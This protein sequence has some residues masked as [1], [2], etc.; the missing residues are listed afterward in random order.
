MPRMPSQSSFEAL[1][2][3]REVYGTRGPYSA[4]T[5]TAGNRD[6]VRKW[7]VAEGVPSIIA[8]SASLIQLRAA[9]ADTS[10][11]EIDNLACRD[12]RDVPQDDDSPFTPAETREIEIER[13]ADN[14]DTLDL[15]RQTKVNG[16]QRITLEQPMQPAPMTPKATDAAG[17]LAA[18]LALATQQQPIDES[19]V[20]EIITQELADNLGALN[21][22][23]NA[24]AKSIADMMAA[25]PRSLNLTINNKPIG[26]LDA[27]RHPRTELLLKVVATGTPAYIV[28]PAGSGKT[29][30]AKQVAAA[31][32]LPFYLQG[33]ASGSHEFLGFLDAHGNYQ[34]TPFRQA[35]EFGGVFLADEI[36]GGD[37]AAPLVINSAISNGIMAFPDSK[38]P[39]AVHPDFRMIAAANTY[40]N[41]AD[42]QYV[43]RTQL[44]AAT[45]D[46]FAMINWQYD[47]VLEM[48]LAGNDDWCRFVQKV[49]R[50][51]A[52]LS[53]RHIVSPRASIMGA[54][55]LA[56]GID[57]ETVAEMF[58]W[59]GLTAADIAR[60]KAGM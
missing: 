54:R 39:I 43:G 27:Q 20:R 3:C 7:L 55:N 37:A 51:I 10:D 23:Q 53:L 16:P 38:T 24:V 33:A 41:G 14:M 2:A 44:D 45:L 22:L 13:I 46:R 18:F 52:K 15:T 35:V 1:S 4:A 19:K 50:A 49:R 29:T 6:A 32:N 31:L 11:K 47:E 34:G 17:H 48:Q 12:T 58:I 9:W 21:D 60:V 56:A 36:D 25:T 57:R 59:K 30:A 42:R 28:G 40:G 5:I 26:T 8:R